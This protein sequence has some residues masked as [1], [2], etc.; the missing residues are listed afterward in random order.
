MAAALPIISGFMSLIGGLST[1]GEARRAAR[2]QVEAIEAAQRLR[3]ASIRFR[4]EKHSEEA[5]YQAFNLRN[6]GRA[7]IGMRDREGLN[8][9]SAQRAAFSSNG[10]D[11]GYGSAAALQNQERM[12]ST[13]DKAHIQANINQQTGMILRQANWE[14]EAADKNIEF[15]A[16]AATAQANAASIAGSARST[17]LMLQGVTG[18]AHGMADATGGG[19]DWLRNR[20]QRGLLDG[21]SGEVSAR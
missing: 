8:M 19:V 6:K 18:F 1:S 14:R 5:Q 3:S 2:A 21:R 10:L 4:A 11:V 20:Y 16:D 15:M 7:L 12:F 17:S 13:F 9:V